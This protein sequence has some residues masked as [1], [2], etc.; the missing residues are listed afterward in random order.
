MPRRPSRV[1]P[2]VLLLAILPA[3]ARASAPSGGDAALVTGGAAPHQRAV[4]RGALEDELHKAGWA[5]RAMR[6]AELAALRA[7]FA[8]EQPW[9]CLAATAAA[10][11]VG[12]VVA[13]HVER[14]PGEGAQLRLTG[15]LGV[16]GST[17]VTLEF[18]YCGPCGDAELAAT[19]R[20][21]TQRLLAESAVRR[22]GTRIEVR[23]TPPGASVRLDGRMVDAPGNSIAASPGTHTVQLQLA[24]Y[25]SEVREIAVREGERAVLEVALV[26][27]SS[28]AGPRGAG[29]GTRPSAA[30]T[31]LARAAG[32]AQVDGDRAAGAASPAARPAADGIGEGDAALGRRRVA[33]ALLGGGGAAVVLGGA[34]LALDEDPQRDPNRRHEPTY[35]DSAPA[36]LA[37][38][39]LG[40]VALAGALYVLFERGDSPATMRRAARR[41]VA[42]WRAAVAVAPAGAALLEVRRPF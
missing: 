38:T 7:C 2:L 10:R 39:L 4:V 6:G 16:V 13:V 23:T 31:A 1:V 20:A 5:L 24:G 29:A 30:A 15:Q 17:Q 25:R 33:W 21:L 36:G 42:P 35:F 41:R 18:R 8:G 27:A 22:A 32:R 40:G 26:A 12:R 11:R 19:A 3:A 34:L 14:D 37:L 9:R 28:A